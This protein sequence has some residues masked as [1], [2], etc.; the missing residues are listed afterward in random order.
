MHVVFLVVGEEMARND[1]GV[2]LFH[3][4]VLGMRPTSDYR[5]D[6]D[7]Y[8]SC[9]CGN[10]AHCMFSHILS[11]KIPEASQ[12]ALSCQWHDKDQLEK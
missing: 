9:H 10:C 6:I 2:L 12:T 8:A 1:I 7:I 5:S 4:H 11:P 3:F